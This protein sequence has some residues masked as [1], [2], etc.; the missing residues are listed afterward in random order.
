MEVIHTLSAVLSIVDDSSKAGCAVLTAK[1]ASGGQQ[2]SED[3][4]VLWLGPAELIDLL[5]GNDEEVHGCLGVDVPERKAH[6][7]LVP[8]MRVRARASMEWH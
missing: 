4:C 3:R 2:V 5:L 1:L 8:L 6:F 7:I